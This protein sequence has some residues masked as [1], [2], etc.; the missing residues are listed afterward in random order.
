MMLFL[1]T[2]RPYKGVLDLLDAFAALDDK[3]LSLVIA[4]NPNDEAG[5]EQVRSKATRDVRV[6]YEP[7]YVPD[8]R[9][10][11][12]MNACDVVVFPYR[13]ILT[14]GAVILAMSFGKAC[15]APL[16]GCVGETLDESGAILYDPRS[17]TG[18][19]DA[20][21]AAVERASELQ[22]MGRHNRERVEAWGW[23]RIAR[24]TRDAYDHAVTR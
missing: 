9:V 1:G 24:L 12:Y 4:G 18:L 20:L 15:V 8:D 22:Q 7:G 13:D 16:I 5:S 23:D 14:S 2:V 19:R 6:R 21:R 3:H 17:P 10:Q 11:V